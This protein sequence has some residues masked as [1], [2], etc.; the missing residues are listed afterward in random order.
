[1]NPRPILPASPHARGRRPYRFRDAAHCLIGTVPGVVTRPN[2]SILAPVDAAWLFDGVPLV[3]GPPAFP[4]VEIR[5]L[6]ERIVGRTMN[7]VQFET[8]QFQTVG[9]HF[10]ATRDYAVLADEMGIGKTIQAVLAAEFRLEHAKGASHHTPHVLILC[11][12]LAKRHWQREILKWTGNQSTILEGLTAGDV[13][14]T[15]YIIANYDILYGQR[16][17]DAAGKMN[18]VEHLGGWGKVL[19]A[20]RF[21][22][23]I[24][25][26]AHNLRGQKSQRTAAVKKLCAGSTCVWALTGTPIPNHIKDL[27]ALWDLISDGLAGYFWPWAKAYCGAF[28]GPYGWVADG[29]SA[30]DELGKRASFWMLGRTKASVALQLPEKRREIVPVDVGTVGRPAVTLKLLDDSR[31][32]YSRTNVVAAALRMTAHAKRPAVVEM[33]VEALAAGQK[34]VVFT[35]LRETVERVAGDLVAHVGPA[36]QI[37]PVHGGTSPEGRDAAAQQFREHI[38]PACFIATIDSAGVAISLVGADLVIFA[39][40]SWD[41]TKLLQAEGRTH[42]FGS[43][44]P[45]LIRYVIATGTIDEKLQEAVIEKLIT[46]ESAIGGV[47]DGKELTVQLGRDMST[48]EQILDKLFQSLI[49]G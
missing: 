17:R 25:D 9:V 36:A 39:D 1:M 33:A 40:L 28:K 45:V 14:Q 26:E 4:G 22:I 11:P 30:L 41:P 13:P 29:Q 24:L 3:E 48:S 20:M 49:R 23:V 37:I 42:R 18:P 31:V 10:L 8:T 6:G 7:R 19:G 47:G 43:T 44:T 5:P 21:P 32:E 12:A 34:V 15:R 46:V 2:G 38:G 35:Y 16:R 27:W